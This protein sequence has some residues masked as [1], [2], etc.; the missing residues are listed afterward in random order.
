MRRIIAVPALILP[1]AA[2]AHPGHVAES[3]GHTH[4]IAAAAIAAAAA[5]TV[6]QVLR[7]RRRDRG[8]AERKAPRP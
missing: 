4:W 7:I 8:A 1:A 3:A 5:V 6:W 2:L